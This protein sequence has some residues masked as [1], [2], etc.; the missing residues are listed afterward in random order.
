M[1]RAAKMTA[2][3]RDHLVTEIARLEGEGRREVAER[4]K[5]AREWGDLKE[6]AEYHAAKED[7]AMLE[8]KIERLRAQLR[9]AE[10]VEAAAGGEGAGMGS[11][12]TY[13]DEGSGREMAHTLVAEVEARPGDGLISIASPVGQT[14]AGARPGDRRELETPR[15]ARTLKVVDV[16][17]S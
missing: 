15:G 12:V 5:V 16:E 1:T 2:A 3:A 13:L 10:V 4:I 14:L 11:K 6:N 17:H 7:A 9:S 8:L